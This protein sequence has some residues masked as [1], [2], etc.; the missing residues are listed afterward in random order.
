MEKSNQLPKTEGCLAEGEPVDLLYYR[1]KR[2]SRSD[3]WRSGSR[4]GSQYPAAIPPRRDRSW[5]RGRQVN[6]VRTGNQSRENDGKRLANL[7]AG[8]S[9]EGTYPQATPLR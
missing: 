3:I 7:P 8:H 6:A 5:R 4:I 1:V 2:P 9:R